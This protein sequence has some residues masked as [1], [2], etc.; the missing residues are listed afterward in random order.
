[1]ERVEISVDGSKCSH[2]FGSIRLRWTCC[3]RCPPA[4]NAI[5][6]GSADPA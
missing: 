1:M 4:R 3:A 5:Y 2:G 6:A